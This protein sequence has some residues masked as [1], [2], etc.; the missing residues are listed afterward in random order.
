[1]P[2][3]ESL[4]ASVADKAPAAPPVAG[5]T[6]YDLQA[7]AFA[8]LDQAQTFAAGLGGAGLPEVQPVQQGGRT[9]YRVVVHGLANS[10][11]AF[12]ARS[13]ALALGAPG[14]TIVGGS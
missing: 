1:L 9:L 11:A 14:A 6:T 5:T 4:L 2:E 8:T 3:V 12:A 13:Q 7:G 10:A